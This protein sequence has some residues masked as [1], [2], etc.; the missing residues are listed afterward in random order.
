MLKKSFA[1]SVLGFTVITPLSHGIKTIAI[2]DLF[3]GYEPK[4]NFKLLNHLPT[5][6]KAFVMSSAVKPSD[7]INGKDVGYLM[8]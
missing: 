4:K 6:A 3:T 5:S 8:Q 1:D 7:E 2:T